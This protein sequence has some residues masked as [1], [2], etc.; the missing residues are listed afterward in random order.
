MCASLYIILYQDLRS[1]YQ[2][3]LVAK[4]RVAPNGT[5][6]LRLEL[7]A[8]HT[9]TKL[10]NSVSEALTF[11]PISTY[12]NGID[13]VMLLCWL[14]NREEWSTFLHNRVKKIGE[15]TDAVWSYVP[16]KENPSASGLEG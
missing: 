2:N 14:A 11:F 1:V 16:T 8:A 5:S 7:V 12:H 4:S 10:E 15:L 9:L 6:I 3:L 13:S